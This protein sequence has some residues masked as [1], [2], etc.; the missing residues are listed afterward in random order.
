MDAKEMIR[1]CNEK[2]LRIAPQVLADD[3]KAAALELAV[4]PVTVQRYLKGEVKN[5]DLG[6][7]LYNL[8]NS[9]IEKR[10]TALT[11]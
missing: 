9:R 8:L 11:A 1:A 7:K 4:N 10:V 6:L 3:R 2:I 5:V